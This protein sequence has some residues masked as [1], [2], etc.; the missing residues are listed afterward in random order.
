MHAQF[1]AYLQ[2]ST[3]RTTTRPEPVS[4]EVYKVPSPAAR[5]PAPGSTTSMLFVVTVV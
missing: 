3:L 2:L 5:R 4:L 1:H